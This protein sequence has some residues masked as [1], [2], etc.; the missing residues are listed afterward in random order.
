MNDLFLRTDSWCSSVPLGK[1]FLPFLPL[2]KLYLTC[3]LRYLSTWDVFEGIVSPRSIRCFL[4]TMIR[5]LH[6]RQ[7]DRSCSCSRE[8][9][10]FL[11]SIC[12]YSNSFLHVDG[13]EAFN[14]FLPLPCLFQ[15]ESLQMPATSTL[16]FSLAL[17]FLQFGIGFSL[18][19]KPCLFNKFTV[20]IYYLSSVMNNTA[21]LVHTI[22]PISLLD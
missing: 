11:P 20:S 8:V 9:C 3:L 7:F 2:W 6:P 16:S 17:E 10:L 4:I 22:P 18:L 1:H 15:P 14:Y 19:A 13:L 21:L 12:T 5:T